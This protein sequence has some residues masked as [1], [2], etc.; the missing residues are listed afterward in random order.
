MRLLRCADSGLLV[1]LADID[2]VLALYD[3]LVAA[4]DRPEWI[5]DLVPAARTLLVVLDP[6][7]ADFTELERLLRNTRPTRRQPSDVGTLRI[8]VRYDGA[9]LS[10]VAELTGLTTAE[11]VTAHTGTEWTV[12]FG[13]FAPGFGYLVNGDPRLRVPRAKVPRTKVPAG[14]VG[15]AGEF[16]GIYPRESPGG[17]QLIGR[18]ELELW[19]T[20]R[21]PPALLRP[22]VRVRFE[23]VG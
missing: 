4:T 10:S 13:G 21:Q 17:W 7:R 3:A 15:L 11:I 22:G 9:D 16:S 5:V 1:E 6:T 2:A 8:P 20:D 19:R 18:T 14:S 12:A 23:D